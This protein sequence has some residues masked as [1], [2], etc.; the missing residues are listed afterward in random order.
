MCLAGID[1]DYGWRIF[2]VPLAKD[3]SCSVDIGEVKLGLLVL[4]QR[5]SH[6]IVSHGAEL[7]HYLTESSV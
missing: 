7:E 4:Q 5:K 2:Y 6:I 3:K 1:V